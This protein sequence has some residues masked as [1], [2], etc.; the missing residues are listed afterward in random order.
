[1]SASLVRYLNRYDLIGIYRL[2]WDTFAAGENR[3][4]QALSGPKLLSKILLLG[5]TPKH[6]LSPLDN[7]PVMITLFSVRFKKEMAY[8][9][10]KPNAS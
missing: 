4:K 1:M 2:H 8:L 5:L 10:K 3:I 7:R 6:V 9:E